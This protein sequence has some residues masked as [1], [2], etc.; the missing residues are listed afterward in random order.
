MGVQGVEGLE[1]RVG[2][3]GYGA[4]AAGQEEVGWRGGVV[5]GAL[6]RLERRGMRGLGRRGGVDGDGYE[7]VILD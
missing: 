4:V 2:G 3:D 7:G 6:V 1:G 5:E